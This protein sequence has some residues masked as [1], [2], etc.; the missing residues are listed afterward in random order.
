MQRVDL[1]KYAWLSIAAA[2][3]TLLL[4]AGA[5]W[6]TGS[7][8]LLSD[9]AESTV[10]LVAAIVALIALKLAAK[11]ADEAFHYGRTKA[12]YF[13]A[14]VEGV[15]IF[16]AAMA[17]IGFAVERLLNPQPL[18]E[19]GIGL[20]ISVIASLIN[21]GVA[22]VLLRAG[23]AHRSITLRADGKHLMT[24]VVTSAGVLVGVGLVWLTGWGW[25]DPVVALLVGLNILWTGWKLLAESSR[26]LLDEALPEEERRRITSIMERATGDQVEFHAVRTRVSGARSFLEFHMLVPG[27]WSVQRG[28]DLMEDLIDEL[29]AEVPGLQVL[30]H[31]EPIEDPRS[32]DDIELGGERT[33]RGE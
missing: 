20:L 28:H 23:K 9:A 1:S 24:D 2:L 32:Y 21:G 26:G 16:L 31:L 18:A 8:G 4:K 11:P 25:L 10:N 5:W 17:I 14:A 19:V 27:K 3:A 29:V 22:M 33:P 15:M 12:E 7:V 13:S 6:I 30:G